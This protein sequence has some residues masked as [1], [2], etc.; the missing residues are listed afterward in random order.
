MLQ[1]A[2]AHLIA[3]DTAQV[4]ILVKKVGQLVYQPIPADIISTSHDKPQVR[5]TIKYSLYL[6]NKHL[7]V[8]RYKKSGILESP[9]TGYYFSHLVLLQSPRLCQ[10]RSMGKHM[11]IW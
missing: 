1:I 6:L 4:E 8:T 2:K 11:C 5:Y 10:T 9:Y 3:P 7:I